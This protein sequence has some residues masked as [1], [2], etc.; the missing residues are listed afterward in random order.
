MLLA[1]ISLASA[2]GM[3]EGGG[4]GEASPGMSGGAAEPRGGG[5]PSRGESMR[6]GPGGGEQIDRGRAQSP[7]M[8]DRTTGQGSRE[9]TQPAPKASQSPSESEKA[10]RGERDRK[11]QGTTG[12]GSREG[13]KSDQKSEK[14]DQKAGQQPSQQRQQQTQQPQ[15]QQGTSGSASQQSQPDA[16]AQGQASGATLS[17]QQQAS[18]QQS[19]LS[20]SNAP[21]VSSVNFALSTGTV[22]PS[23]V[24]VVA[25]STF[26]VLIEIFPHFQDHT[27]FIV[28]DEIV[29]LDR[30][31]RIVEVVP[32]SSRR[33]SR[34]GGTSVDVLQLSEAEI[35]EVQLVLVQRGLLVQAD[36][37]GVLGPKTREA[38]ITFQR[39]EGLQTSGSIDTRTVAALG[40]SNKVGS[41][42]QGATGG[43]ST[44]GQTPAGAQ[45]SGQQQQGQQQQQGTTGQGQP[46]AQGQTPSTSGQS[47]STTG[48]GNQQADPPAATGQGGAQQPAQQPQNQN[49]SPQNNPGG[50][51]PKQ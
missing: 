38:L 30:D 5:A 21:R 37:D 17:T 51:A 46:S 27:F 36:V 32:V 45:Q 7:S 10:R 9:S 4:A 8:Q 49:Q 28:E 20:A 15:R 1:G 33:A 48:Q 35:R 41:Q 47:P 14:S 43:A 40:L 29:I 22:V 34:G 26:P 11:D 6:G 18:L 25:V 31:R 19:V 24:N 2:Q 16:S 50:T 42:Q 3:K 39:R 44:T 23:H 12:Q 13:A